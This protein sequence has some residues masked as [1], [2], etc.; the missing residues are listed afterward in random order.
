MARR[1]S[2]RKTEP[3]TFFIMAVVLL[4]VAV[5]TVVMG[6]LDD[7]KV[8]A[9]KARCTAAAEATVTN[10]TVE[11][12]TRTVRRN[13]HTHTETYHVYIS[14]MVYEYKGVP[15]GL[16]DERT[17]SD[18]SKG[19][20]VNIMVDPDSPDVYYLAR[21]ND[22]KKMKIALIPC[23]FEVLMG[24][25]MLIAGIR[26]KLQKKRMNNGMSFEQWQQQQLQKEAALKHSTMDNADTGFAAASENMPSYMNSLNNTSGYMDS[27]GGTD[28][29]NE[30]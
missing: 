15:Y 26:G 10:V 12:R 22:G 6:Y 20:V 27:I 4:V 14:D 2:N 9:L 23:G 21:M 17:S 28:D 5:S 18:F 29:I 11:T 3:T 1:R 25:I 19:D 16:T 13:K 8:N 7:K 24:L 30:G